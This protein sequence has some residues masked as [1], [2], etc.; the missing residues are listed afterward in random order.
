MGDDRRASQASEHSRRTSVELTLSPELTKNCVNAYFRILRLECFRKELRDEDS[1]G[2]RMDTM[3]VVT[4]YFI[5]KVVGMAAPGENIGVNDDKTSVGGSLFSFL[6]RNGS[7]LSSTKASRKRN[8]VATQTFIGIRTISGDEDL[9]IPTLA[10]IK[11]KVP[12]KL[13]RKAKTRNWEKIQKEQREAL[14]A[15][16]SAKKRLKHITS[17]LHGCKTKAHNKVQRYY[18]MIAKEL[19][20]KLEP[21]VL[22]KA[23][24]APCKNF[25][26]LLE[27]IELAE[28]AMEIYMRNLD[29]LLKEKDSVTLEMQDRIYF[30]FIANLLEDENVKK[31]CASE[32]GLLYKFPDEASNVSRKASIHF[33][34]IGTQNE[35]Q[36]WLE[37]QIEKDREG[38]EKSDE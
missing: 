3:I 10:G 35:L 25:P 30:D 20:F 28:T 33:V 5:E 13:K 9:G 34:R 16:D 11:V 22:A 38:E 7:K 18:T 31:L 15:I 17:K 32:R 36:M 23:A 21:D 26:L 24:D 14:L 27:E 1:F 19:E 6:S 37:A 8:S 2:V 29:V 12:G 4:A